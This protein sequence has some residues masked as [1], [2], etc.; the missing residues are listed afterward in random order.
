MHAK[1][2]KRKK[3][4]A[5]RFKKRKA[6][7]MLD[8]N[9]MPRRKKE[10]E[11]KKKKKKAILTQTIKEKHYNNIKARAP[12]IASAVKFVGCFCHGSRFF[13]FFEADSAEQCGHR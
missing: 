1:I 11:K 7:S 12:L 9:I 6:E 5:I 4:K 13:V 2:S 3:K 8:A 10:K